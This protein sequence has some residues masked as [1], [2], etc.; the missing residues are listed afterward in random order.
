MDLAVKLFLRKHFHWWCSERQVHA[1]EGGRFIYEANLPI[2]F[3]NIS[4]EAGIY[5]ACWR[6][7]EINGR[8]AEDIV[9]VLEKG[10]ADMKARPSHYKQFAVVHGQCMYNFFVSWVKGYIEACKKYPTAEVV[11]D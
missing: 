11:A 7:W 5:E 1:V 8:L 2:Y 4:I 3:K 9:D 10:Y 6:P